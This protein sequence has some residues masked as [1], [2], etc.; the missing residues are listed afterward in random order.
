MSR[1]FACCIC[2][3]K[4]QSVKKLSTKARVPT[5]GPECQEV[6][7]KGQSA[8][9]RTIASRS[10]QQRPECQTGADNKNKRQNGNHTRIGRSYAM[11]VPM[12]VSSHGESWRPSR[13]NRRAN[14]T[15]IRTR[16]DARSKPRENIRQDDYDT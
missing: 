7:N 11:A 15:L 5:E 4:D 13:R 16:E 10:H 9:R 12:N 14:E 2:L 6:I 1:Q 8:Y 3:P